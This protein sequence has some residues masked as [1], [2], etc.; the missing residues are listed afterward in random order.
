MQLS[1]ELGTTQADA[2]AL[3]CASALN[4]I[5]QSLSTVSLGVQAVSASATT[6][7]RGIA[8][9]TLLS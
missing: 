4:S 6:R 8:V 9:R 2:I 3:A 5:A 1:G 7:T